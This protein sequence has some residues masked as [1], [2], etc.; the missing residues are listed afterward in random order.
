VRI[1]EFWNVIVVNTLQRNTLQHTA[2]HCNALQHTATHCNAL[3]HTWSLLVVEQIDINLIL[4]LAH[5]TWQIYNKG[6]YN[7][8]Q[9]ALLCV[10][11][12]LQ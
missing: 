2:T 1:V 12:V 10:A 5:V 4:F 3:H 7:V 9:D 11:G 6:C 8:L